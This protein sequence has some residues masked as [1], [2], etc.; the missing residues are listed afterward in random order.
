MNPEE[1]KLPKDVQTDRYLV[2][3]VFWKEVWQDKPYVEL[4]DIPYREMTLR[5]FTCI[6]LKVPES[7]VPWLDEL[8]KKSK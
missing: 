1:Q 5:Q 8:I 3:S 6:H 2:D 4:P 7:G